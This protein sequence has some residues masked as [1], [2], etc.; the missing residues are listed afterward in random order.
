MCMKGIKSSHNRMLCQQPPGKRARRE[1][2][3]APEVLNR[4][5]FSKTDFLSICIAVVS[6]SEVSGSETGY[7]EVLLQLALKQLVFQRRY[8]E[9][10]QKYRDV[11]IPH[12]TNI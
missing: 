3:S 7:K 4:R 1:I 2:T 6:R 5:D 9:P 8:F 10:F 11:G 12:A